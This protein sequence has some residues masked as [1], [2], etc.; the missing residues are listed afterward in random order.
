MPGVMAYG[1]TRWEA[2][3]AVRALAVRVAA[4]CLDHGENVPEPLAYLRGLRWASG[5]RVKAKQLL[6]ALLRI[7]WTFAWR[8]GS[9]GK[10]AG[11]GELHVCSSMM[12][13]KSALV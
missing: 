1:K 2:I 8:N 7:G 9:D 6:S 12:G 11:V 10:P 3:T 5:E 4:D 13:M